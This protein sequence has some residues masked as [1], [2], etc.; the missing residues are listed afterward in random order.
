MGYASRFPTTQLVVIA[1]Q[2]KVNI[3]KKILF[4]FGS[5][6]SIPAGFPNTNDITTSVLNSNCGSSWSLLPLLEDLYECCKKYYDQNITPNY[7]HL[8]S[9]V[10]QL[11]D[12]EIKE[13]EN[14][15]LTP[16]LQILKRKETIRKHG[17]TIFYN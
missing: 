15:G 14:P 12:S 16:Y 2:G 7:E 13:Y 6:I 9:L 4:L 17:L 3:M 11:Y 8:F 5:G 1:S 10:N